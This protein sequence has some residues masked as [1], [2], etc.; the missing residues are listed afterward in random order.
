M[1]ASFQIFYEVLDSHCVLWPSNDSCPSYMPNILSSTQGSQKY[2]PIMHQLKDQNLCIKISSRWKWSSSGVNLKTDELKRQVVYPPPKHT[3][4]HITYT[5]NRVDRHWI[6]TVDFLVEMEGTKESLMHSD[7]FRWAN[8]GDS[9]IRSQGLGIILHGSRFRP[10]SSW[11]HPLSHSSFFMKCSTSLQLS[12]FLSLLPASRIL[13]VQWSHFTLYC[14]CPL[15]SKLAI[16]TDIIVSKTLSVFCE[17]HW[18][19]FH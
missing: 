10:L 4:T 1:C 8:V 7:F 12:S 9:F 15:Q 5:P 17:S 11:F 2:H 16:F 19:S 3:Y 6:M 13:R 14:H 18:L